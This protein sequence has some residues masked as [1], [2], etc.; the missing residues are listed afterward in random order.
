MAENTLLSREP[1]GGVSEWRP[2]EVYPGQ[3]VYFKRAPG[4]TRWA[5]A[6]V[7]AVKP[8]SNTIS[9]IVGVTRT[10]SAVNERD[11][12]VHIDDPRLKDPD[13]STRMF[14]DDESGVWDLPPWEKSL[15]SRLHQVEQKLEKLTKRM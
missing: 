6:L 10:S 2:P 13:F 7:D 15:L 11:N 12:V 3:I 8:A 14:V 5:Y 9:V 4:D 1:V